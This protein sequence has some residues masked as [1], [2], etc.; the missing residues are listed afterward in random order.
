MVDEN[1]PVEQLVIPPWKLYEKSNGEPNKLVRNPLELFN[2]RRNSAGF[3]LSNE[4]ELAK[5][6]QALNEAPIENAQ[7]LTVLANAENLAAHTVVNPANLKESL[8]EV[9]FLNPTEAQAVFNAANNETW[10]A[11]SATETSKCI[12][13][14]RRFI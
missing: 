10:A 9:A 12:T 3:D 5:L 7:S 14:S 2:D 11:Q 8:A 13:K 1:I 4:F 6:E